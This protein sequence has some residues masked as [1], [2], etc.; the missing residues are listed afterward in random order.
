VTAR[1]SDVLIVGGGVIG[2]ACAYHLL[3]QGRSVR[4][5]EQGQV[6]G[7]S[8]HGNCG[9]I[10]PSHVHPLAVPGMWGKALRW[11][12]DPGSPFYV[13]PTLRPSVLRWFLRFGTRCNPRD[14]ARA[15]AGRSALLNSSRSLYDTLVA[16]HHL[17]CEWEP[18]GLLMVYRTRKA[19]RVAES[20]RDME[21]VCGV[22]P[23][24]YV[25][26]ALSA[27]EPSLREDLY[28]GLFYAMDADLRPDLLVGDLS[29]VV[30]ERGAAIEEAC[31]VE[32]FA[33]DGRGIEGLRT[34]RGAFRAASTVLAAGAWTPLVAR[35]IG[36]RVP[37]EP[38]KGYTV[39]MKRPSPCPRYPLLLKERSIAVT[40]WSGLYRLGG[41]LEFAG[42][43]EGVNRRRMDAI[44]RGA[45]EYLK[46]PVSNGEREEWFGWRP[47]TS[48]DL[49]FIG[50]APGHPNL[51][52]AAGHGMM[53]VSMAPATGRL[54]AEL[55]TGAAPHVDPAPYRLERA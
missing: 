25:G 39:T 50:S 21:A 40:P 28:G 53:G 26:T 5:L 34:A 7:G 47:M 10:T 52:V 27:F 6:G 31:P 1:E 44:V 18:R 15:A 3:E 48:D 24:A 16:R 54:V 45:G 49:P 38:G 11:M 4:I 55:V 36:V 8:S 14:A 9:L 30:R 33:A 22:A 2:L 41:T 43:S 42:Y 46:E 37:I 32:G 17:H 23:T 12:L 35:R 51:W 19:M 20:F 29:R 13:K